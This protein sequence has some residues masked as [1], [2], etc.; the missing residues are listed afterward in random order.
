MSARY[1]I[2][3]LG[4]LAVSVAHAATFYVSPSGSDGNAGTSWAAAKQTIQAGINA[5]SSGDVVWVTN[6]TYALTTT[7]TI[8]SGITLQCNNGVQVATIDGGDAVGRCVYVMT[9]AVMDGFTVTNGYNVD[10]DNGSGV[11][12]DG[13]LVQNC[14]ISGNSA[15]YGLTGAG[16]VYNRGGTVQNCTINGNSGGS[17]GGG[18]G[19]GVK[20]YY[21][22]VQNC[23][24]SGNSV[25]G[26]GSGGG[27]GIMN[28]SGTVRNCII[29]GNSAI[30]GS[31]GGV[32]NWGG[33]VQSC[34][35][36]RNS[37]DSSHV[38]GVYNSSGY[39]GTVQ[40]CIVYYNNGWIDAQGDGYYHNSIGVFSVTGT[41][42]ITND[43]GFMSNGS[44][45]GTNHVGGDYRLAAYST[46]INAGT[47]EPWMTNATDIAGNYRVLFGTV[48]IGAYESTNV[49]TLSA[50][51]AI[52]A[53]D[54]SYVGNIQVA[55]NGTS[56]ASG[57]LV[58]RHTSNDSNGAVVVAA[59]SSNFYD[60]TAVGAGITYFYWVKATNAVAISVLSTSDSGYA[61]IMTVPAAPTGAI[62]SDGTYSS[63]VE[64]TWSAV[65]NATS[66]QVWRHT[67]ND[68]NAASVLASGV[69]NAGYDD[70]S[71]TAGITSYYW[72]K[73]V[74]AAG[75]SGFSSGDSGYAASAASTNTAVPPAAPTGVMAS[76]GTYSYKVAVSWSMVTNATG[77]QVWRNTDTNSAF[78]G[79]VAS[80]LT[81]G[82]YDDTSV[83][84]G[85][86]YYYWLKAVNV[87]GTSGFSSADSGYA[88]LS[89]ETAPAVPSAPTGVSASDG[90]YTDRV[91]VAWSAVTNATGYQVWRAANVAY[92]A[93]AERI[94]AATNAAYTDSSAS[95]GV[96][97]FYWIA[98][99]N[100]SGASALSTPDSGYRATEVGAIHALTGDFDGDRH[101]DFALYAATAGKWYLK[102]SGYNY[103]T[104]QYPT[105]FGGDAYLPL[106]GDFDGDRRAD[107]TIY[108]AVARRWVFMLSG[109]D[110]QV[111]TLDAFGGTNEAAVCGDFDGDGEEDPAL[112]Q[113]STGNWRLLISSWQYAEID[114]PTG[115]GG[116]GYDALAGDFDGDGR[117]D[118][119]AYETSGGAWLIKPSQYGYATYDLSGILLGGAFGGSG[120]TAMTGDYDGDSHADFAIYQSGQWTLRL[121]SYG[122]AAYTLS[123]GVE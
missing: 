82:G 110:Y 84:V 121:S 105:G 39:G 113:E 91:V 47:N 76:D 19:G 10:S 14:T 103:A 68:T 24:I 8:A 92:S 67:T 111:F 106:A 13:G 36:S 122:Y 18:G 20:N 90:T 12:N 115:F 57:Y 58:L 93:N 52:T 99:T 17:S 88:A 101:D 31:G 107:F 118:F 96:T 75:T 21:G 48:D 112:H 79:L 73:A 77:Y 66:Y 25:N 32:W 70:T 3:A 28:R 63:K 74:N 80:N 120:V 44:G 59:T 51:T 16:G 114:F 33:T 4:L 104:V 7:I 98:A 53:S 43:P 62:A 116:S 6:G 15:G 38:G 56:G 41:G 109:M 97:Y 49:P 89:G 50:P 81:G 22:T 23:T 30:S 35:V 11:Y 45:Y 102:L 2:I 1:L 65:T 108:N 94:G 37:A 83:T 69:T 5:A 78:A 64:V 26:S 55:W 27:G 40:N 95:A 29:S 100:I 87:S 85:T 42:N 9:N 61:A 46:C 54:G 123:F 60:D 34:T 72:L 71:V 119:L 117:A 86:T